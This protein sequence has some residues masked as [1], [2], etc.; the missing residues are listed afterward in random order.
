MARLGLNTA[1]VGLLL[2]VMLFG[3]APVRAG[4][5][6]RLVVVGG[7]LTEIVYALG[8]G[9]R[10]VGVD[11]T[12]LWPPEAEGLPRVGYARVLA[13]EGI[14]SLSPGMLLVSGDAGPPAVLQQIRAAGVP[15]HVIETED[16][17]AGLQDKVRAV[18]AL[19]GR[20]A[21]GE[22]L[23]EQLQAEMDALARQVAARALRPRVAFLLSV[24]N[25]SHLASGR[26]TAAAAAIALAGGDTALAAY[27]GYKPVSAEAMIA[28]APDVLLTTR[29]SLER[30]GGTA[31]LL[32]L[33]GVALTPAARKGRIEAMDSLF[34]LGFGPRTPA[35]LRELADRLDGRHAGPEL[36]S[37]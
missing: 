25:G 11:S 15:V 9:E 14:L 10:V 26:D 4:G 31:G 28:A 24:G 36:A 7:A 27:S 5:N 22:R 29:Q 20:E 8:A 37:D 34:L 12:S 17:A 33:P 16:S 32:E 3:P 23:A 18:A 21:E 30:L 2:A 13:A 35:A 6:E 1:A 19:V